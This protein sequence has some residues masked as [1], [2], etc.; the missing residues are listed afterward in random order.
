MIRSNDPLIEAVQ[1]A[2]CALQRLTADKSDPGEV[3]VGDGAIGRLAQAI[4]DKE[5]LTLSS[6]IVKA[7][8]DIRAGLTDLAAAV[9]ERRTTDAGTF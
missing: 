4:R 7:G 5:D 8:E 6:A 1:E 2:A 3:W 9:R